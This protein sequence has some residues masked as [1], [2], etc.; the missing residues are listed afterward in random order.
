M[1]EIKTGVAPAAAGK[2]SSPEGQAIRKLEPNQYFDVPA[3]RSGMA[4][5]TAS[6]YGRMNSKVFTCRK[7]PN[8]CIRIWRVS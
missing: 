8:G 5:Q 7:Q 3:N 4:R 2:V 6:N 1:Y